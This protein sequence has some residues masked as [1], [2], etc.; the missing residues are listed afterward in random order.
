M[1]PCQCQQAMLLLILQAELQRAQLMQQ[2]GDLLRHERGASG[3]NE[4]AAPL[5]QTTAQ[6]QVPTP[7][8]SAPLALV[9]PTCVWRN[10]CSDSRV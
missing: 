6:E 7:S 2:V 4:Q 10:S 1:A 5:Q 3:Y 9:S 8:M